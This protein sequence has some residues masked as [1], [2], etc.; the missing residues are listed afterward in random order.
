MAR[1]GDGIPKDVNYWRSLRKIA[2]EISQNR[3]IKWKTLILE[4]EEC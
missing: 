1:E 3:N 2:V 4:A